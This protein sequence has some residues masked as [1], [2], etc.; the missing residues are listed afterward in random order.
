ML[1]MGELPR[2]VWRG[3]KR[4]GLALLTGYQHLGC[5]VPGRSR[6]TVKWESE[7]IFDPHHRASRQLQ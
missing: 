7:V 1:P 4:T 2:C 6:T 3:G 5:S